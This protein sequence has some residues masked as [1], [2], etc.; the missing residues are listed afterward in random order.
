[1]CD[2]LITLRLGAP[3][4]VLATQL[5][6]AR[7][8]AA[9][10]Q[11]QYDLAP[12]STIQFTGVIATPPQPIAGSMVVTYSGTDLTIVA[13]PVSTDSLVFDFQPTGTLSF[14]GF[15]GTVTTSLASPVAGSLDLTVGN[16][17]PPFCFPPGCIPIGFLYVG[18]LT[19]TDVATFSLTGNITC[20]PGQICSNPIDPETGEPT[21]PG[22]PSY[23]PVLPIDQ[24]YVS[25]L[26]SGLL[27]CPSSNPSCG[28]QPVN[29]VIFNPVSRLF[30]IDQ[31]ISVDLGLGIPVTGEVKIDAIEVSRTTVPEPGTI[32][33]LGT[34]LVGLGLMAH[35]RRA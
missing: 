4:L 19:N 18:S 27:S 16:T 34:G 11:V 20:E 1:M 10:I 2:H 3:L 32:G 21:I 29:S 7:P 15:G 30:Q 5:L 25:E 17:V 35:R 28:Q 6:I 22:F 33:L 14:L 24:E 31:P 8:I 13:G 9:E 26:D 23:P 12:Q